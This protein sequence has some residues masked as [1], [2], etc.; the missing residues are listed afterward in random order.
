[1]QHASHVLAIVFSLVALNEC[2]GNSL[3][4]IDK[5][6]ALISISKEKVLTPRQSIELSYTTTRGNDT[7]YVRANQIIE[8]IRFE[9][10]TTLKK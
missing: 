9:S 10:P 7:Q 2:G 5:K 1:M 6:T 8:G 4:S 3:Q